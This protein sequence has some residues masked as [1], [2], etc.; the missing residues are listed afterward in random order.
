[1]E[2]RAKFAD[3]PNRFLDSEL[4]LDEA[5][6]SLTVIA[7]SPE[8]YPDLISAPSAISI[9]VSLLSHENGDIVADTIELISELT[10]ADAIED[11]R[12]EAAALSD[13]LL[14]ESMLEMLIPRLAELDE[15]ISEEA[16]AVN[17]SLSVIENLVDIRPETAINVVKCKGFLEWLFKRIAPKTAMNENKQYAAEILSMLLQSGGDDAREI[18]LEK[19][20]IEIALHA[21]AP[22]RSREIKTTE[23][24]EFVEDVFDALCA[25]LMDSNAK[26]SFIAS[27]GVELLI[28]ILKARTAAQQGA[29]K[30]LDFSTTQNSAACDIA[31]D[32]G[33][34]GI[35][36]PL[37]MGR[38]KSKKRQH[39]AVEEEERC[40][41]ILANL[42]SC[43]TSENHRERIAAKFVENEFEKCD[44][45]MEIFFRCQ[46]NVFAEESRFNDSEEFDTDELLLVRLDAGLFTLQQ[47]A[48]IAGELWAIGDLGLRKRIL[49]LLHQKGESMKYLRDPLNELRATIAGEN[50][51]DLDASREREREKRVQR[52]SFL[53]KLMGHTDICDGA[54]EKNKTNSNQLALKVDIEKGKSGMKRKLE[55]DEEDVDGMAK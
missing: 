54:S 12:E 6:K 43:V 48:L 45:L 16:S 31:V 35:I 53:L 13:A 27:E 24:E 32:H 9:L 36:S 40:I 29:L 46:E 55:K 30:C 23:E 21:V 11:S 52:I 44:R 41:S 37:L 19:D 50:I 8:V 1:M 4:D 2:L 38:S 51:A 7:T 33:V 42:F 28:L 49:S 5:I 18:F 14:E 17:N 26:N 25:V 10:D 22:Y 3:D 20:G 15:E 34:L 47:C 39:I